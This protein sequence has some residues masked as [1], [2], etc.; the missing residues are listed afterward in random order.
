MS[1]IK[2]DHKKCLI[3]LAMIILSWL[4]LYQP[5]KN[6]NQVKKSSLDNF[7]SFSKGKNI[8]I[9]IRER[10]SNYYQSEMNFNKY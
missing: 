7:W 1:L 8:D 3:T 6:F 10:E 9:Y 2:T 5:Q 4:P